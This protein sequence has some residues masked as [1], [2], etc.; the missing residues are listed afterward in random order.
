MTCCPVWRAKAASCWPTA[1]AGPARGTAAGGRP[2]RYVRGRGRRPQRRGAR[3]GHR[4]P[5]PPRPSP[6]P[7]ANQPVPDCPVPTRRPPSVLGAERQTEPR[8]GSSAPRTGRW[9]KRLVSRGRMVRAPW[10]LRMGCWGI[11]ALSPPPQVHVAVCGR[12][13]EGSRSPASGRGSRSP[14]QPPC[15]GLCRTGVAAP[16][17]WGRRLAHPPAAPART[18]MGHCHRGQEA[19][20]PGAGDPG[21]PRTDGWRRRGLRGYRGPGG[22]ACRLLCDTGGQP[23]QGAPTAASVLKATRGFLSSNHQAP[24]GSRAPCP[25]GVLGV[26]C[27]QRAEAGA[28]STPSRGPFGGPSPAAPATAHPSVR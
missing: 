1:R 20:R 16:R 22:T 28:L 14:T 8:S 21:G 24:P 26:G 11:G 19:G 13:P 5:P 27:V 9:R 12:D 2:P 4:C 15:E 6:L 10:Q 7:R 23:A 25:A 17:E 18:Q 3:G